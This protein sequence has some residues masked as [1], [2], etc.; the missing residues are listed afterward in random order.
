MAGKRQGKTNLKPEVAEKL[1][2]SNSSL[3][4]EIE[5]IL[6]AAEDGFNLVN[7]T[8]TEIDWTQNI[9]GW[10]TTCEKYIA[11][12]RE[13]LN[14][15]NSS[16]GSQK[17]LN[18]IQ[19][20]ICLNTKFEFYLKQGFGM[21]ENSKKSESPAAEMD[22]ITDRVRWSNCESAFKCRLQTSFII[23]LIHI[24]VKAFLDDACILFEE[25][26]P[27]I[28]KR[29]GPLK[30][31]AV[32]AAK[33]RKVANDEEKIESK[34]FNVKNEQ[35]FPTTV[36]NDW[37]NKN[38]KEPILQKV[39]EFA[40]KESQWTLH[41]IMKL[42]INI[43]K[44]NAIRVGSY[45]E[46]PR[47]IKLKKACINVR[48]Y[49][50]KC[51]KWAV[52]SALHQQDNHPTDL[53]NYY[54]FE[55]ELN[56]D[57]I[58]FPLKL[59]DISKFEKQNNE[60]SINLYG[61]RLKGKNFITVP[62]HLTAE[63]KE[64]H[65]NLLR[66]ESHY[67]DEGSSD[68]DDDNNQVISLDYHYVWIK[69]LSRLVSSQVSKNRS[70][71]YICDRCL[72]YFTTE[73]KLTKHVD[74]CQKLNECRIN[75]PK[76]GKNFIYF[77]NHG[78]KEKVPFVI[79]ADCECLLKPVRDE[80]NN[81]NTEII[82]RHEMLSI[83]YYIKCSYDDSLS[84]YN[85]SPEGVNP[86]KWFSQV[87]QKI[88]Q[89]VD[90]IMKNPI[91]MDRLTAEEIE[92]FAVSTTCHICDGQI[93]SL[94]KKVRDHS[95]LTGKYRGPAH[96]ACNLNYQDSRVIPVVFHNLSG[97]DAHFIIEDI[98]LEFE[99]RIELLPLNK[100][101]YISFSKHV[102]GTEIKFRFIDSF[103]FMASSLEKLASYLTEYKIVK[104]AFSN[105]TLEEINLLTRKGVLPYEYLD[106]L[107][108]LK[109]TRLPDKENFYSTLNDSGI[110]DD[111]Y[112]HAQ[113]VWSTFNCSNLGEYVDLYMKTDVLLLTDIFENF[114]DQCLLAYGLDPAHYYTTPGLTWDA[115]LKCTKVRLELLTD[116][117]K[118]MFFERGVR[119]GIS[120][121]SN[122]YACANNPFMENFNENE[123]IKYIMYF[124]AN[125]L[126]GWGMV[127]PLPYGG[128]EWIPVSDDFDFNIQDDEAF[129]YI[130]E[131]DL[132]YP[133]DLHD[134]HSDFPFCSEHTNPPSELKQAKLL[135]TLN[136]K[137]KYIIHCRVLKQVIANG[138]KLVKI[139]RIMKFNQSTWLKSYI[140]FNT[141]MR[142][143]AKNEFEKNLFKL[144][145][146]AVYGKTMEN[147]R[148]HVDVKLV[149]KWNGRY[150]AEALISKPNFHSRSIFNENLVAIELRKTEILMN[151]PIYIGF[152]VLDLSKML[153]YDFHYDYMLKKYGKSCKLMYTDT[154]SLIYELK[155]DDIFADM[156]EDIHKFDTSDY[157]KDN[158]YNIPQANNK[159][160][161]LMKD[162]CSGKIITEFVGLRS[163]M[164]SI[165][166]NGQDFT[167]KA[168]GV[169]ASVVKKDI[170]FDD[171]IDCLHN[172]SIQMRTQHVIR[173]RLHKVETVKQIK[174]A[175]SPMDNKRYL[176]PESSDTLAWGHYKIKRNDDEV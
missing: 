89:N 152:S 45:I 25:H 80:E 140:D 44:Y 144:M 147:V 73:E 172:Y 93:S 58:D 72:H 67:E 118:L 33:F 48:N 28:I 146:N 136:H 162:E 95:H 129:S 22:N 122:R 115:M 41:S 114:R 52:L 11:N 158:I 134:S 155:C 18:L 100:E 132:D 103:K 13:I 101:K 90:A 171:Y 165:R 151:K 119:G 1:R 71:K 20:F 135:T 110:S 176:L 109:E 156:R 161:G 54:E 12:L 38:I 106:N 145:N 96:E 143:K 149:T 35:I 167:K 123:E 104:Q 105:F 92:K 59:K 60:I 166:V 19:Q 173:S 21:G 142:A 30:V 36:L 99:G 87:L 83:G 153:I 128:F 50:Q 5:S 23:N 37:Y 65:V 64:K 159:I 127:Q 51:F 46:L 27:D 94:D 43:N 137:R 108:K 107:V 17:C 120:Q 55:N 138:L 4:Q 14:E 47:Q 68:N 32:L 7:S 74:E 66:V 131:V 63:K 77:K 154:D 84:G 125:N 112:L 56:C 141:S 82:Q 130:L 39:E 8:R 98:C 157:P 121:C 169:K 174:V 81:T 31:Y 97:Y 40:E 78:N 2:K 10:M 117:D 57:G 113:R 91:P 168:K 76:P 170:E 29:H 150:G 163:K 53:S 26:I 111:D 88:A 126:Y 6:H 133:Q 175:L 148:K 24:D 3:L 42:E 15:P 164:Y 75:L 102:K 34:Y 139:H 86:A 62:L 9:A 160:L 69:N 124:D 79:Y 70:K 49:D 116:I 61:L 16:A 85:S